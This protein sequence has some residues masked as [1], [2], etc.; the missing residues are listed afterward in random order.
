M[1]YSKLPT[2]ELVKIRVDKNRLRYFK[3][4][5]TDF[6][7]HY[8]KYDKYGLIRTGSDILRN[9]FIGSWGEFTVKHYLIS[10]PVF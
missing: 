7:K 1:I 4:F 6:S 5:P 9:K 8:E 10:I 3:K 2:Q